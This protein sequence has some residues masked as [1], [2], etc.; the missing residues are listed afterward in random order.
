MSSP[1]DLQARAIVELVG[2]YGWKRFAIIAEQTD[3]GMLCWM[4]K[5]IWMYKTNE[6]L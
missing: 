3:Y 1:D 6:Y 4:Y 2:Y 5:T